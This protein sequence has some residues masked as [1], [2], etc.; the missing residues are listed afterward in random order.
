[1]GILGTIGLYGVTAVIVLAVGFA[2]L[3][4]LSQIPGLLPLLA[5]VAVISL[6]VKG[7]G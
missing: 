3:R 2:V 6:L 4:T 7:C 5:T 1:M